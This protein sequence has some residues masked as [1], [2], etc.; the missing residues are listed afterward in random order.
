MLRV[1]LLP[2]QRQS[3]KEKNK[4]K[5][6]CFVL[7]FHNHGRCEWQRYL[8]LVKSNNQYKNKGCNPHQ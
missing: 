7:L 8:F 5:K 6:L 2:Q 1:F 4:G 3:G